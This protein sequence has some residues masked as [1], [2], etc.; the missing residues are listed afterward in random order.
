MLT[1]FNYIKE[2]WRVI[3]KLH[4]ETRTL[5]IIL[6]FGWIMYS[7]ITS[8]TARQIDKKHQQ[9]IVSNKK[10]EQYSRETAIEIN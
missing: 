6:L 7:Q 5:I 3:N 4:P 8:E 9:E 2:M 10:A 1:I